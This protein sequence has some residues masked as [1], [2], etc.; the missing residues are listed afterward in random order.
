MIYEAQNGMINIIDQQKTERFMRM[1]KDEIL[2]FWIQKNVGKFGCKI[3][4]SKGEI[5]KR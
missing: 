3:L 4:N 5:L 2:L 1:K